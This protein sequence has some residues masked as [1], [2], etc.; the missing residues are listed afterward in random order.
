MCGGGAK[1][2]GIRWSTMLSRPSVSAAPTLLIVSVFRNQNAWPSSAATTNPFFA[3]GSCGFTVSPACREGRSAAGTLPGGRCVIGPRAAATRDIWR[4][5]R[6]GGGAHEH[7][8]E[9]L[10]TR[11]EGALLTD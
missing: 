7:V 10:G 5:T 11:P 2:G 9:L 6:P 1:P 8:T 4:S 3:A